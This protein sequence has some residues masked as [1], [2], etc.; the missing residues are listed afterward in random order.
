MRKILCFILAVA[1]VLSMSACGGDKPS[2]QL[3][4]SANPAEEEPSEE[5]N[6]EIEGL[7]RIGDIDVDSGLFNVKI[8][9]PADFLEEG[10]TQE[11]LDQQAKDNG[12][13]SIT[14]NDDGSAT[15]VMTKAQ[16]DQMMGGIKQSIDQSISELVG[17]DDNPN[18]VSIESNSDYTQYK[19]TI[20]TEEVGLSEGIIAMGLY[21][22]SGMYHVFNGTEPGNINIQYI[23]ESTGKVIEESNSSDIG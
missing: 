16:H 15:Y 11:R 19:V 22:Y 3:A 23:N 2:D 10:T 20:N 18:I 8:T 21:I 7:E 17:S 9:I 4:G 13:K 14:L 6:G 5:E 1:L 12:Y